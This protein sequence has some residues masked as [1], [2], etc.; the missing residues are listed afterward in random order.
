MIK[1]LIIES[2]NGHLQGLGLGVLFQPLFIKLIQKH[3]FRVLSTPSG[4]YQ[5]LNMISKQQM[6]WSKNFHFLTKWKRARGKIS[7][8]RVFWAPPSTM[9][10]IIRGM[11]PHWVDAPH[12]ELAPA[13][14]EIAVSFLPPPHQGLLLP[15]SL[16]VISSLFREFGGSSSLL[17]M[18]GGA[19]GD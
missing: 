13:V 5:E 15:R 4:P 3:I 14:L 17:S 10:A 8:K 7:S 9:P 18:I 1:L 19:A 6:N 11:P 2:E 12:Q 16:L